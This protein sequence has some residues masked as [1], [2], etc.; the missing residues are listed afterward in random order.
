MENLQLVVALSKIKILRIENLRMYGNYMTILLRV[1]KT[2]YFRET[3]TT[4]VSYTRGK[5]SP[6]ES[7]RTMLKMRAIRAG[8]KVGGL[9]W[10]QIL[11]PSEPLLLIG[12]NP[13]SR[14]NVMDTLD[15][16]VKQV[17]LSGTGNLQI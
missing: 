15:F 4:A 2:D 9:D 14:K 8:S 10:R 12:K 6:L 16:L 3:V 1:S 11:D 13:L 7:M 5:I 17:G